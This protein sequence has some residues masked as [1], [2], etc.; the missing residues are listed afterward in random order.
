MFAT[1][2]PGG[3][4]GKVEFKRFARYQRRSAPSEAPMAIATMEIIMD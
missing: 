4:C 1:S 2:V 3:S